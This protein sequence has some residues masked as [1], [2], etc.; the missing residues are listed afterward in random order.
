MLE[1]QK[2]CKLQYNLPLVTNKG[3]VELRA[4]GKLFYNICC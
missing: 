3:Q 2:S 1:N 4:G